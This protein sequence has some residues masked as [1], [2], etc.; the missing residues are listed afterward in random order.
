MDV[1]DCDLEAIEALGFGCR[2]FGG[3]IAAQVLVDNAAGGGNKP[4]DMG[5]EVAF[6]FGQPVFICKVCCR[7]DL[8]C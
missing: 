8:F 7:V 3:N 1:F 2:Y 5:D 4:K 6:S